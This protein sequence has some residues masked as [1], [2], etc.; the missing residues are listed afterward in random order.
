MLT[1]FTFRSNMKY[2]FLNY[3]DEVFFYLQR[4]VQ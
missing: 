3:T 1:L 4:F 2:M